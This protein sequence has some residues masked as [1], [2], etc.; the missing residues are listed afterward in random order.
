MCFGSVFDSL[1]IKKCVRLRIL[2]RNKTSSQL[3]MRRNTRCFHN[4]NMGSN[5]KST[6]RI[7]RGKKGT[8][9]TQT[10]QQL[11]WYNVRKSSHRIISTNDM[12]ERTTLIKKATSFFDGW[13]SSNT[14]T[15]IL[16][17]KAC[18]TC[19]TFAGGTAESTQQ[20]T[21]MMH[22]ETNNRNGESNDNI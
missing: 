11:K 13:W 6:W 16:T 3:E 18:T 21:C 4:S 12:N 15:I 20:H 7:S 2:R 17:E 10:H 8:Q 22:N 5:K 1:V 14:P 9:Q 19:S